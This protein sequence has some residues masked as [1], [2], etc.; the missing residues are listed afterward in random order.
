MAIQVFCVHVNFDALM[1]ASHSSPWKGGCGG[2]KLFMA[3][4]NDLTLFPFT[5]SLHQHAF[6]HANVSVYIVLCIPYVFVCRSV[7][8][9]LIYAEPV[10]QCVLRSSCG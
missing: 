4:A 6:Q 1:R 5:S 8:E 7:C 2:M 9:M 10:M 3:A